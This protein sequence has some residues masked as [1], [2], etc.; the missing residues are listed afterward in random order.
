MKWKTNNLFKKFV[1][2]LLQKRSSV[3]IDNGQFFSQVNSSIC[4]SVSEAM[5]YEWRNVRSKQQN[6][7]EPAE[8]GEKKE[9]NQ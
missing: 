1:E 2:F 4:M 6:E 5:K 3:D 8:S 7:I 9:K